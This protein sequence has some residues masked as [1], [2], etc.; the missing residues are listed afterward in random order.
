MK[1][2]HVIIMF[3]SLSLSFV[4]I[5]VVIVVI[6]LSSGINFLNFIFINFGIFIDAS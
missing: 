2:C 6:N 5:V 4:V 3:C 1:S